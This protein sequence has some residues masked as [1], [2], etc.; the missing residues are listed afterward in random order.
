MF[1]FTIVAMRCRRFSVCRNVCS[2]TTV[3]TW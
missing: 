1:D 3:R 2:A